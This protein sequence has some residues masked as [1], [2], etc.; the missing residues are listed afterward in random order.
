MEFRDKQGGRR[1]VSGSE[2]KGEDGEK[3]RML[4]RGEKEKAGK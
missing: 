1:E 3:T 4:K 2:E